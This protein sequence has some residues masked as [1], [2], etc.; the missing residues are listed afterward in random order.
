M[1]EEK[2][3]EIIRPF[4]QIRYFEK[5]PREIFPTSH[6]LHQ[7]QL[8]YAFIGKDYLAVHSTIV[9]RVS[10]AKAYVMTLYLA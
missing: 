6:S 4:C 1:S 8:H 7:Q 5:T 3:F 9:S 10:F 2:K